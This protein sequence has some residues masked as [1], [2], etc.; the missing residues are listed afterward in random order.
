M[1]C[2]PFSANVSLASVALST[3]RWK[4][5]SPAWNSAEKASICTPFCQRADV[6]SLASPGRLAMRSLNCLTWDTTW[7]TPIGRC[8]GEKFLHYRTSGRKNCNPHRLQPFTA[9]IRTALSACAPSDT[10]SQFLK[11]ARKGLLEIAVSG[12]A[13]V[14]RISAVP[15]QARQQILRTY[16]GW[17]RITK[18][19]VIYM[20]PHRRATSSGTSCP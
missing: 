11:L 3:A 17:I 6:T 10:T 7:T 8:L 2:Q 20:P 5:F 19:P 14:R 1:A 4:M 12:G 18:T 13:K 16:A 9:M 15:T